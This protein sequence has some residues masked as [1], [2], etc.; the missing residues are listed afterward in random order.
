MYLCETNRTAHYL[1]YQ[2]IQVAIPFYSVCFSISYIVSFSYVDFYVRHV[3]LNHCLSFF[4]S[5]L[6]CAISSPR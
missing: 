1:N 2:I 4:E 3:V 6:F 5:L